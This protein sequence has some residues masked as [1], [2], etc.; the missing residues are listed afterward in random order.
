MPSPGW[1]RLWRH[2]YRLGIR[3]LVGGVTRGWPAPRAG[4]TRLLVPLD[5]WRYYE[6]GRAADEPF[7]GRCLDVSSP[8]LLPS[9]LQEERAG[10]WECIDLF[11]AEIEAWRVLDPALDLEVADARSLPYDDASFDCCAFISVL[12]HVR[13]GDDDRVLGEL[14]RVLRP[15]GMLVLTTDVSAVARDVYVSERIYGEASD[16]G[17]DGVFFKHDYTPAEIDDLV[18]RTRWNVEYREF[19]VQRRPGIERR[20]YRYAPWSYLLGPLLRLVCPRNFETAESPELL[21]RA[22]SGVV[23]LRLRRPLQA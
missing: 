19:A 15:G 20:F 11:E 23:Y 1:R 16:V 4:L 18:A 10:T 8:K 5:P 17:A 7:E 22:R 21:E 9:L 14:H 12:E 6:L 3:W 2:S 13:R